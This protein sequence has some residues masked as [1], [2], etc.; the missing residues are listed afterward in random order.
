MI[1]WMVFFEPLER[2]S[3]KL[4]K[5]YG[6][7]ISPWW[8]RL[9]WIGGVVVKWAPPNEVGDL[10]YMLPISSIAFGGYPRSSSSAK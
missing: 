5:R 7:R 9:I 4:I 10:A 1:A 2:G 6:L 8:Y 3:R